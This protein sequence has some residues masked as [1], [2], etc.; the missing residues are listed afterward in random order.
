[1]GVWRAAAPPPPLGFR[2]GSGGLSYTFAPHKIARRRCPFSSLPETSFY[3]FMKAPLNNTGAYRATTTSDGVGKRNTLSARRPS[4]AVRRRARVMKQHILLAWRNTCC[5][6][7]AHDACIECTGERTNFA[8]GL[9]SPTIAGREAWR[10]SARNPQSLVP[11]KPADGRYKSRH[12]LAYAPRTVG[13][14]FFLPHLSAA[15]GGSRASG[16]RCVVRRARDE[17]HRTAFSAT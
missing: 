16:T 6:H 4:P 10:R 12:V 17:R 2:W 1:M 9:P 3:Q 13:H 15:L 11:P 8:T 5:S 14:P 7:G